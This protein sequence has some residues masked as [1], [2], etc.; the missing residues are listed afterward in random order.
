MRTPR[1]WWRRSCACAAMRR[2]IGA[3]D[4]AA[5]RNAFQADYAK[6]ENLLGSIDAADAVRSG[7]RRPGENAGRHAR[8]MDLAGIEKVGPLLAAFDADTKQ[9]SFRP[10]TSSC[11]GPGSGP[12]PRPRRSRCRSGEPSRSSCGS[13]SRRCCSGLVF[14][15]WIGRSI[16]RPLLG[17]ANAMKRLAAGDTSAADSGDRSAGRTRRD[18][19]HGDRVP[20]HHDRTPSGSPRARP[21]PTASARSAARR[22]RRPSPASRCRSTRRSPRCAK[23]R[24]AWKP[25]PP[26][27]TTPPTK[28]PPRRAPPRSVSGSR[29][30]T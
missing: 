4:E 29:R 14:S 27:S 6:F 18:G 1:R 17:L 25:P 15:W 22:S 21:R 20:R 16:T 12:R 8:R 11:S 3:R 30:T 5:S 2:N 19:A 9:A 7:D 26:S 10:P 24:C 13:A 28:S 23:Q